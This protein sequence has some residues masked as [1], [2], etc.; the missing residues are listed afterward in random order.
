MRRHHHGRNL[1]IRFL[2]V[3]VRAKPVLGAEACEKLGLIRK[4]WNVTSNSEES[5][6]EIF[7]EYHDFFRGLGILPK[8]HHIEVDPGVQQ[9]R[10]SI[11]TCQL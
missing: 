11:F 5:T 10:E 8:E 6:S 3:N 1:N 9:L 7:E 2:V 4:V